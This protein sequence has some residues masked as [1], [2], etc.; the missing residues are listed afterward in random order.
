MMQKQLTSNSEPRRGWRSPKKWLVV[1]LAILCAA[2]TAGDIGSCGQ[3]A[4]SLDLGKFSAEKELIDCTRCQDC[5]LNTNACKKA[6]DKKLD[7][8]PFPDGCFPLVHD[9]EVCLD[10][11][12]VA[13]CSDY[14]GFVRDQ[15]PS[16]PTECNFCPPR[17]VGGAGGTSS[18]STGSQ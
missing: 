14:E 3:K 4:V 15:A 6:C 8:V 10:E 2:P 1:C 16:I 7:E 13:S 17:G 9:G 5:G 18:G 11:L 12:F